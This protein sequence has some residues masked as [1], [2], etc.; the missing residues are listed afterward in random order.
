MST[1]DSNLTRNEL[2]EVALRKIGALGGSQAVSSTQ[3][4]RAIQTLNLIIREEDLK[5]TEQSKSLWAMST[6][7]LPLT[8]SGIIYT[9]TEGLPSDISELVSAMYRDTSG[10]DVELEIISEQQYNSL[11]D[12]NETG[13]PQKIFL[14]SNILHA[15]QKLYVWPG[16]TSIGTESVVTG[17]DSVVY[18]CI[19]G[20]TAA[21][22]NKPITGQNYQ[23][24]WQAGGS[25][26]STWTTATAYT[27]A[28]TLMLAYKRPL[29]GFDA[30]GDN[31]DMPSGWNRY[32]LYRLAY[33]LAPEYGIALD[34]RMWMRN[35][36]M[37]A[38]NTIFPSTKVKS[39]NI[40]NKASYM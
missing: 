25:G 37:E 40:Y 3:L 27:H 26:P 10:D 14:K 20:H 28:A 39:T 12:K 31:P 8:A 13:D 7:A 32:L 24:Y 5:Q 16:I 34:E 21:A 18:R 6:K 17:T 22:D 15:S 36:F 19:M 23:A 11:A 29:Y 2:I 9:T 35:E 1:F 33:D 4:S 38:Y 30:A